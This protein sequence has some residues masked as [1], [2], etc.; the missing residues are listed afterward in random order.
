MDDPRRVTVPSPCLD[1]CRLDDALICV[2][3]GRSAGEIQEWPRADNARRLHIRAAAQARIAPDSETAQ[4][5]E[6]GDRGPF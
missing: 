1:I 3:C 2:G 6:L 4:R 5:R